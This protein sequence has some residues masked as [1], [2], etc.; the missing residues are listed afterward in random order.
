MGGQDG[1]IAYL[2]FLALLPGITTAW[3]AFQGGSIQYSSFEQMHM[4]ITK[5][6]L[7]VSFEMNAIPLGT[8]RSP[9]RHGL[10]TLSAITH[11]L[12]Y[13]IQCPSTDQD[14]SNVTFLFSSTEAK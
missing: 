9:Y 2:N 1:G 4:N 14:Q 12:L 8:R 11:F 13:L 10:R 5:I 3:E 6:N 7:N